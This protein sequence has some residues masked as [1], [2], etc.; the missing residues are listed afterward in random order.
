[1]KRLFVDRIENGYAI[2]ETESEDMIQISL[3]R[4]PSDTKEGNVFL[5]DEA[6]N[7]SHDFEFEK[8][9]KDELLNLQNDLFN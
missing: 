5:V 4:L 1:M 9:R 6:E 8:K 2:C 3:E 7:Y